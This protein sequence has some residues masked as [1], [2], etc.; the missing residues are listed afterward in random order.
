MMLQYST[1]AY[2]IRF[3]HPLRRW[4]RA[5]GRAGSHRPPASSLLRQPYP[6][7]DH[8]GLHHLLHHRKGV[9]AQ[10]LEVDHLAQQPC[11]GIE[12]FARLPIAPIEG[13]HNKRQPEE[14]HRDGYAAADRDNRIPFPW[15]SPAWAP[16]RWD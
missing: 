6:E 9:L 3:V 2:V 5:A 4:W 10:L 8:G 15:E 11:E 14:Q 1:Q 7:G 16:R 13:P 12:G